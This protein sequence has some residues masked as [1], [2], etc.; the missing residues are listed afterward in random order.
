M[1]ALCLAAGGCRTSPL[2]RESERLVRE[3]AISA[4]EHELRAARR[5]PAP[6]VV[7]RDDS[8]RELGI[9]AE[10]LPELERMAGPASYD[11]SSL[12]LGEDLLGAPS[13][14]VGVS[15]QSVVR[16]TVEH[17]IAVQFARLGVGV[18]E[19]Q[20]QAA[21]AA[22]DWTFFASSSWNSVNSPQVSS[23]FSGSTS[24]VTSNA[25]E[26][27]SGGAGLRR[28][29]VGGGRFTAQLDN[30]Y[31]DNNTPGQV[32]RPNPA[33][34]QAFLLQW[35]QPLLRNAGSEVALAE[36]RVARNSERTA[37]QTLRRDLIR[38]VTEA[39]RTYWDLVR[40][41]YDVLI[42]Q[43]LLDR[44]IEV[45]RQLEQRLPLDAN[46]AQIASAR[47]RV[48]ARRA[49]LQ[50]ARTQVRVLSDRLKQ[51][52]N[53]PD[54]PV[55][56]EV[57]V[58]PVDRP[59]DQPVQFS[60]LESLRQ[61]VANRPEVQQAVIAIDDASIRQIVAR[62]ARLPDLTMRLQARWSA[63]DQDLGSTSADL[64]SGNF[65]DYLAGLNFEQAIGNRRAEADY[66]RRRLERMQT[67][68]AYRNSVQSAAVEVKS[69]LNRVNLNYTLIAQTR[70]SRLAA[71]EVL[72]V[73][74]VEKDFRQG[75]TVERLDLELNRQE[76]LAAAERDEVQALIEYNQTI[77]ELFQAIGTAL[78]RNNIRVVVPTTEDALE[79]WSQSLLRE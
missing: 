59:I 10:F 41:M 55:G 77:A 3:S 68:L 30:S 63:L 25:A 23:A 69:A 52:M 42:L 67:V 5:A 78:E 9:R 2:A 11:W 34:Q 32:N 38:V 12:S 46:Q 16:T 24:P 40:S 74:Q 28:P 17:N 79:D 54:V 27:L 33:V 76:S 51:L 22:F 18:S 15:L 72:R 21:E 29:L 8:D 49:D 14:E 61:A 4:T 64:F 48:E 57:I 60:L 47:A 56:S 31:I 6:R 36:I 13:D 43:R 35:D 70:Q 66:R 37:V 50:R 71:A 58:L 19:A 73:L 53:A 7:R 45:R 39:E 65:I 62:N 26:T 20:V 44:G 1:L 75:F